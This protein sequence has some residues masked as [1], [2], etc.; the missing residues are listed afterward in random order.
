M[1]QT[2]TDRRY[3]DDVP[4]DQIAALIFE[5]AS[6]LHVERLVR[7]IG[8][9]RNNFIIEWND[10]REAGPEAELNEG[11]ETETGTGTDVNGSLFDGDAEERGAPEPGAANAHAE[12]PLDADSVGD[13]SAPD[14]ESFGGDDPADARDTEA[15]SL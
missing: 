9:G 13:T 11:A 8:T 4:M 5:L 15:S 14:D 1:T 10:Q 6:Q 3:L 2:L 12:G 7:L